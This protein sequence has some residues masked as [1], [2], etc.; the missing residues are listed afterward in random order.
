[1]VAGLIRELRLAIRRIGTRHPDAGGPGPVHRW[2]VV[3]DRGSVTADSPESKSAPRI[4]TA[5]RALRV[6]RAGRDSFPFNPRHF[7]AVSHLEQGLTPETPIT[8][9]EPRHASH[10]HLAK[11]SIL[12]SVRAGLAI[13]R[14]P[15]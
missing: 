3:S 1:A 6:V 7:V 2:V 5:K 12:D 8:R 10:L 15:D 9:P 11:P 13:A 14:R 4:S